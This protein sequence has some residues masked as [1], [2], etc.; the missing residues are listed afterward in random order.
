MKFCVQFYVFLLIINTAK[1]SSMHINIDKRIVNV[2]G[3][4]LQT[5]MDTKLLKPMVKLLPES[6]RKKDP[7]SKHGPNLAL[8]HAIGS[9][10]LQ[11]YA[12][13]R[14]N[15]LNVHSES[16]QS[17]DFIPGQIVQPL[18]ILILD[19]DNKPKYLSYPGPVINHSTPVLIHGFHPAS[20]LLEC[21]W[22]CTSSLEELFLIRSPRNVTAYDTHFIFLSH[23]DDAY[24]DALWMKNRVLQTGKDLCNSG[25]YVGHDMST[26][27]L[28]ILY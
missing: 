16:G 21:F 1:T 15:R 25:K 22:N 26:F 2:R 14:R 24:T 3:D 6:Q 7:L 5:D 9:K 4:T 10:N 17:G 12:D 8:K 20:G 19:A 11:Y 18:S 27:R 13:S 23:N 28:L